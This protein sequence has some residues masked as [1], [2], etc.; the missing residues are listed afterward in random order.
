MLLDDQYNHSDYYRN[1]MTHLQLQCDEDNIAF[2]VFGAFFANWAGQLF[3]NVVGDKYGRKTMSI[4]GSLA[5][6]L[7]YVLIM[8]PYSFSMLF[9]YL[10]GIGFMDAYAIQSYILGVEIT[11]QENRDAFMC[12]NQAMNGIISMIPVIIFFFT[13]HTYW[14]LIAGLASG[15]IVNV[16]LWFKVPE[17]IRFYLV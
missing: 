15:L 13:D 17:S 16:I 3:F 7:A 4:A 10:A 5:T 6:S 1:P 8:L 14:F 11:T 12:S 2:L 9:I